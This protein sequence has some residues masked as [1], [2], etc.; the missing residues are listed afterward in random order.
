[1]ITKLGIKV[2]VVEVYE[3]YEY[4]NQVIVVKIK[5]H[6][7]VTEPIKPYM[8]MGNSHDCLVQIDFRYKWL[9]MFCFK[10]GIIAYNEEY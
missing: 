3:I 5:S 9:L 10:C 1:M 4:P 7:D 8:H 2:D 6:I